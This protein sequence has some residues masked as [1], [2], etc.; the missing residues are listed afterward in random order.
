MTFDD[1]QEFSLEPNE[2]FE[3]MFENTMGRIKEKGCFSK[4]TLYDGV[5][6]YIIHKTDTGIDHCHEY[7]NVILNYNDDERFKR[8]CAE[9]RE[10]LTPIIRDLRKRQ[11]AAFEEYRNEKNAKQDIQNRLLMLARGDG[12]SPWE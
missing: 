4:P 3:M 2:R 12:K 6:I 7:N 5:R 11:E 1:G 9:V 10:R 8:E